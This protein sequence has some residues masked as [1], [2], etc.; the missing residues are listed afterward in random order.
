V[1]QNR[2]KGHVVGPQEIS[3][4][5]ENMLDPLK[6]IYCVELHVVSR[7]LSSLEVQGR[8]FKS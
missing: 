3:G 6:G 4:M 7:F 1:T 2:D 8:N 5:P